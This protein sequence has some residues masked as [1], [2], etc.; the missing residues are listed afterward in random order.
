LSLAAKINALIQTDGPIPLSVFMALC[1]H[2]PERGYYAKGAGLGR[3]FTTAPETSQ[4]F[5]ELIGLWCAHEWSAMDA[6]TPIVITELG[7]GRGTLMADFLRATKVQTAFRAAADLYLIE[8]SPALRQLQ[9]DRLDH[10]SPVHTD[11]L[12]ILPAGPAIIIA[13][14]FLDC[15]PAR[16]FIKAGETWRERVVGLDRHGGLTFGLAADPAP[17][18]PDLGQDSAEFQ[19]AL[20]HLVDTLANRETPFRALFIDY[21]SASETPSDTLRAF[22]GGEQ[23]HPL[24]APGLSDLT[25]DVD[26]GFLHGL[27]HKAGLAVHG[28]VPQGDFLLRLGAEARLNQ[29]AKLHPDK[30]D[31]LYDGIRELVDPEQMGTRFNAIAISSN[32]LPFPAGF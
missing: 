7:P 9:A 31:D 8:A 17:D 22:Q 5:G 25:V 30:A 29:L 14:E 12:D 11:S 28:P 32:G 3:D 16:Q 2:D 15:L 19:P 27:A 26:F 24:A 1:L 13:N 10:A 6:P 4:V 23:I 21:G 20:G 18:I